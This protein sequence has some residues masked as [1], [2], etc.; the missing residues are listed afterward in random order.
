MYSDREYIEESK[1]IDMFEE[2]FN[3]EYK[4]TDIIK[5]CGWDYTKEFDTWLENNNYH[6]EEPEEKEEEDKYC[7]DHR[8]EDINL[9]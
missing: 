4:A 5:G 1:A 6:C 9:P 2:D 7:Y 8:Y 3:A